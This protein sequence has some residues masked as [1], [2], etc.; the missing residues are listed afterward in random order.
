MSY[1]V[2]IAAE[3]YLDGTDGTVAI[4]TLDGPMVHVSLPGEEGTAEY[5]CTECSETTGDEPV[6][7]ADGDTIPLSDQ[8]HGVE[9]EACDGVGQIWPE[10]TTDFHGTESTDCAVCKSTGNGAH[11]WEPEPHGWANSARID[12]SDTYRITV[13]ISVGDPRGAFAMSVERT[14]DGELTLSLPDPSDSMPHMGLVP[15]NGRGYFRIVP[16]E[17]P[18]HVA[19]RNA[20]NASVRNG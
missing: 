19:A 20:A 1:S 2:E 4:A 16:S 14:P 13:T 17:S 8:C 7:Y 15:L 12:A 3:E 11:A 9:C 6:T 10:G 18:E 5:R